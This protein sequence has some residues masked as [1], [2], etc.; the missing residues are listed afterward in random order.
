MSNKYYK[1]N[2]LSKI[3][4]LKEMPVKRLSQ[5]LLMKKAVEKWVPLLLVVRFDL[6]TM[7]GSFGQKK[8]KFDQ[9]EMR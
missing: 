7:Q 3:T 2:T 8:E 5:A 9:E 6:C 4:A 1:I